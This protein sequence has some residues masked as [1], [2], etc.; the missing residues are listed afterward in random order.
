VNRTTVN[1][2][3]ADLAPGTTVAD[4]VAT[5]CTSPRGVAVALNG[6]VV[7]RSTWEATAVGTGDDVEIVT[8]A[9]GG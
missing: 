9:A 5:R 4:L 8:A 6:E 7:P 3:P 1:G 2:A